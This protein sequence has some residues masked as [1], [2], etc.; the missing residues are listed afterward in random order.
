VRRLALSLG[1]LLSGCKGAHHVL[2]PAGPQAGRIARL[3]L[4][5]F[6]VSTV[7][8]L[9]VLGALA[10]AARAGN[11][12]LR[13]DEPADVS[14][15]SERNLARGVAGA[16][17]AT[18]AVLLVYVAASA[19]TGRALASLPATLD[20]AA[21]PLTIK[22]TGHQ[23]WWEIEYADTAPSR[24]LVTANEVHIPVGRPVKIEGTA[25]DVIHSFWVPNLHGK[26]DLI[27]GR[28][29]E[30]WIQADTAG[31]WD[32]ACAEFCGH[33]HAK[34]RFVVVAEPA[35][36]FEAWYERQLQPAAEPADSSARRGREVF[37]SSSCPMCHTVNGT[38]AGS[39]VGPDLTHLASRPRIAAGTLPN[40][41]GHLA[42]WILD[43]QRIKPGVRMPANAFS[44][45]DL[46][47][48]LDYLVT[49][50]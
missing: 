7:V 33:Q 50:Q 43:P 4:V 41:R 35:D 37:L 30:G 25:S 1:L 2:D 9:L 48:L 20:P 31:T 42:G 36:S 26:R 21:T 22:V 47:A 38:P 49:L 10:L 24:R 13:R 46:Q 44:P 29:I 15:A 45:G 19:S 5:L 28:P 27:P 6:V 12:R 16:A 18:A 14:P 39:R 23:W 40:T 17:L 11:L 32:G 3:L 34:M 8:Y